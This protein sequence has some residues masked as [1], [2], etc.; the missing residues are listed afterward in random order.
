M[1]WPNEPST[2]YRSQ[3]ATGIA[4]DALITRDSRSTK[5]GLQGWRRP[6]PYS[7]ALLVA[8]PSAAS[9]STRA[10]TTCPGRS[11]SATRR[12]PRASLQTAVSR[13]M[14]VRRWRRTSP[15]P[16]RSCSS[17]AGVSVAD[18]I[19]RLRRQPGVAYAVP[20]YI[21]HT[22]GGWIPT[23]RA[24]AGAP[25]WQWMQWNFLPADGRRCS[26]GVGQPDRRR[27]RRAAGGHGGDRRHRR[28]LPQLAPVHALA[29][30]RRDPLRRPLRLRRPQ[31]ATRSTER[32]WDVR[33]RHGR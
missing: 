14:G 6:L 16:S 5:G 31:R 1:S 11:L 24:A 22:A 9:A 30:L 8:A 17:P 19:A 25:G 4:D 27:A 15:P 2:R 29:G 33:G 18:A 20:N 28:R 7:L 32:P 23:T 12:R 21:A 3:W 13:R 10:A 26:R